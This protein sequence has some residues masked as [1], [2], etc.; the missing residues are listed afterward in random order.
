[1]GAMEVPVINYAKQWVLFWAA[2]VFAHVY[3]DYALYL[4]WRNWR[5]ALKEAPVPGGTKLEIVRICLFEILLQR[6]LFGVSVF[7]WLVHVLIFWGFLGLSFLS[8]STFIIRSLGSFGWDGGLRQFLY[9]REGYVFLKLWGDFFGVSLLT[10]LFIAGVRR[11]VFRPKQLVSGEWD[12]T[13]LLLLLWL[14]LSGF[15][16][17]GLRLA[18]V[19]PEIARYSF[20]GGLFIPA[21]SHTLDEL[22]PWLRGI[23]TVHALSGVGL[24]VYLPHSKLMHS[25]LAPLVIAL[26]AVQE[27]ERQDI[28]WPEIPK[29]KAPK[30]HRG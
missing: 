21:G 28:Y 23:W 10:G 5:R 25:V 17:E 22:G 12:G 26:N 14:A 7:R 18:L 24:M 9:H 11:F 4:N 3:M 20:F 30:L 29:G 15:V 6:Q 27:R 1:M 13:L 8:L 19:P 2:A 16:L